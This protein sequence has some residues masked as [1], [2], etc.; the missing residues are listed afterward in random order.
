MNVGSLFSG[1]G[2][3]ERGVESAYP[4]AEV[5]WQVERDAACRRELARRWP[6]VNREVDDVRNAGAASLLPVDMVVGGFPCQD[7]SAAG[8]RVGLDGARSGL[9]REFRR[10]VTE[11]RSRWV[12]VENVASGARLWLPTVLADLREL[13]YEVSAVR[14]GACDV[15]APHRRWR[16][17]VRAWLRGDPWPV[18]LPLPELSWPA[19]LGEPQR[20]WEPPRTVAVKPDGWKRALAQLGNAVVPWSAHAACALSPSCG[21]TPTPIELCAIGARP[22]RATIPTPMT[23]DSAQSGSRALDASKAAH[24]GLSLTDRVVRGREY[25]TPSASTYGSNRGVAAGRVGPERPS[26]RRMFLTPSASEHKGAT[27]RS[28]GRRGGRLTND[29]IP[30]RHQLSS[31]MSE[32]GGYL[33]PAWVAALMGIES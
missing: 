2:G 28:A 20:D 22:L 29:V 17:F 30:K 21:F 9:W 25:P 23:S 14:V 8:K 16:I 26:L 11:L 5:L 12:L 7:V 15:G 10:V 32:R 19:G 18:A 4:N 3:L 24:A 27:D 1:I 33:N 13:G 6:C 31:D